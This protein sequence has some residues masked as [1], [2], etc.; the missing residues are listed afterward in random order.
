MASFAITGRDTLAIKNRVLTDLAD[1]DVSTLTFPN[2]LTQVKTGKDGNT[3]F[4]I[5][6]TG[7]NADLVLR[8]VRGSDDDKFFNSL[9]RKMKEDFPAFELMD[10]S[11]VKKIGD[12]SGNITSDEYSLA[13]GVFKKAVETKESAEGDTESA[14]SI[15]N[16]TFARA[17]RALG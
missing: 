14:V 6:Q 2:D 12:G 11:F 13:G 16:L 15:Y 10:G 17:D 5:N 9:F 1:G 3:L 7:N 4:N 8:L